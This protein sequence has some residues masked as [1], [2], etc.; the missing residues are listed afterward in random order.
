MFCELT[1]NMQL[2]NWWNYNKWF[3][4]F[5]YFLLKL[6]QI[7]GNNILVQKILISDYQSDFV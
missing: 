3:A 7:L 2:N 4:V 5:I 6:R 1:E